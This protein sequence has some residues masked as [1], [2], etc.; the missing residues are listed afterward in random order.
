MGLG[1]NTHPSQADPTGDL[2]GDILPVDVTHPGARDVL[3]TPA[4]HP[5]LWSETAREGGGG[6]RREV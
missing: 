5:H 6:R 2:V 1:T 4:T 3:H